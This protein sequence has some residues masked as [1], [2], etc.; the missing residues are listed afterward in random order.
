MVL[1]LFVFTAAL[2]VSQN[3]PMRAHGRTDIGDATAVRSTRMQGLS[4]TRDLMTHKPLMT[5]ENIMD[6][7]CEFASPPGMNRESMMRGPGMATQS[8]MTGPRMSSRPD[9]L[10]PPKPGIGGG[11]TTCGLTSAALGA[12]HR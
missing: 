10:S 1:D 3:E 2:M 4:M 11:F 8:I 12:A 5:R 9:L 6:Q 7:S